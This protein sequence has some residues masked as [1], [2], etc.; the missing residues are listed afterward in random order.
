MKFF[1]TTTDNGRTL[2]EDESGEAVALFMPD[3]AAEAI[4]RQ[5]I[6]VIPDASLTCLKTGEVLIKSIDYTPI[7]PDGFGPFRKTNKQ[8]A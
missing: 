4:F 1:K 6:F 5:G 8:P 2:I 7:V 3:S